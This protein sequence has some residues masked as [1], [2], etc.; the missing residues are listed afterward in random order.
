MRASECRGR[1]ARD[2][3]RKQRRATRLTSSKFWSG[4]F[5][6]TKIVQK[7]R[8]V[9]TP[10]RAPPRRHAQIR[11]AAPRSRPTGPS[12]ARSSRTSSD[13]R[14]RIAL[15]A[16]SRVFRDAEK[17]DASLPGG[18]SALKSSVTEFSCNPSTKYARRSTGT[19]RG[20]I[21]AMLLACT[22]SDIAIGTGEGV[23]KDHEEGVRVAG[24][25]VRVGAR[26]ARHTTSPCY[27]EIGK[28]W[29]KTKRRRS[30]YTSRRRVG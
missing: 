20:A 6:R 21:A 9:R 30:S 22:R 4:F 7:Y 23:E 25:S 12:R 5:G 8:R 18:L 29:I 10:P 2:D 11:H 24:K 26:R 16:V 14:D 19:A 15:A 13:P 17:S 28:A 27:Y 1:R 3:E